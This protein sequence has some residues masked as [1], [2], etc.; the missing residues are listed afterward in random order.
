MANQMTV[1]EMIRELTFHKPNQRV[2]IKHPALGDDVGIKHLRSVTIEVDDVDEDDD[3]TS[4]SEIVVV[5]EC[6]D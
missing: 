4:S 2:V 1:M 6:E 3:A 5:I